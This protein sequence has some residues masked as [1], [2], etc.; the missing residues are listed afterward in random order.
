MRNFTFNVSSFVRSSFFLLL[1]LLVSLSS[2]AQVCGTPGGDGPIAITGSVNTYFPIS[3]DINLNAGAQAILLAASPGSDGKGNNFGTIPISAGD[4]ILII[5][6]QDATIDYSDNPLYG[7]GTTNSGKDLLGGTGFLNINNT[8]IFEYVIATNNVPLAGGNLTF[9]GT[10]SN[11]GVRNSFFN[12]KATTT[13]GQR[14]FQIVRVPQYSNLTLNSIITTPPFNGVAG[15]V[16][17]FNVSGTFNFNGNIIDGSARGFRGGYSPVAT[18]GVNNDLTYVGASDNTA[19]SGKGEGIAG[20]PRYMWDGFSQVDNGAAN[21]GLPGGSSGRGAPAN[22]GGGGN[23]HNSGGGGGGN[24][25]FGGLGGKGWQGGGGATSPRTG[26]GR[27]GFTS[28]KTPEPELTRLIMGGGG[29][30]GDANNAIN[31]V[32]GGV[33]GAIILINAGNIQGTGTIKANGG[34]GA[35]GSYAGAPDGAG[36]GG[37]G[38]SVFLNISNTNTI[39]TNVTI[40]ANG[41]KG[42][43]TLNDLGNSHGPGGG[44]GGGIIRY[45]V[46][47]TGV[48]INPSVTAGASGKTDNGSANGVDHGAQPGEAGSVKSF[49]SSDVPPNLQVNAS[50]FPI[51]ETTVKALT[52]SEVCG[53]IGEKVTYEI[54]IKNTGAG[55]AAGVL[56]DFSFPANIEFDAATASYSTEASGPSGALSSTGSANNPLIGNFNIAQNGVVTITLVGRISGTIAAGKHSS[57]AQAQYL[58]PT[59]RL[60]ATRKIT[61]A[62]N[63]YGTVNKKYEGANQADVPGTNFNG[64]GST[65]IVDDIT[66]LALPAA[67]TVNTTQGN[68]TTPTGTITVTAPANGPSV[69]YTLTG[70]NPVTA[71]TSNATGVFPGLVSGTYQVTT[72][73][74]Q[75]CTSLPTT[76]IQIIA[77]PGAPTTTGVSMCVGDSGSLKATS[78]SSNFVNSGTTISGAWN[79]DTDPTALRPTT[80]MINSGT[81]GFDI[82][83]IRNYVAIPFQ[84]SVSGNYILEMNA[85]NNADPMGYIVSGAFV[86]GSCSTGNW[87]KGDDDSAGNRLPRLGVG[88]GQG[89]MTLYAGTTYTLISTTYAS[90]TGNISG[91]FSWLVTSRPNGGEIM[92]Q[93]PGTINWY[94]EASGGTSIA[95]GNSFDPVGVANSGVANRTTPISTI[96]YAECSNNPGCRTATNFVIN[97]K[98]TVTAVST[99]SRCDSGEVTLGATASSGTINWYTAATGGAIVATGTSYKT[100]SLSTTTDYYVEAVANGCTSTARTK[101]TATVNTTPTI[102]STTP[103]SGC[104]GE[105][106]TLSAS[107]SAGTINWYSNVT[108]GISLG[109]GTSFTTPNLSVT[110]TYY[111]DA[112]NNNCTTGS[113]VAVAATVN[114]LPTAYAVTGGGTYCTGGT[115]FAV[116]L[117][118][119]DSGVSYQ[120]QLGGSNSGTAVTGTGNAISFGTK[121]TAGTYTVIATNTGTSCTATMTGSAVITISTIPLAPGVGTITHPTCTVAT[122]SVVLS[123]LPSGNWTINPGNITGSTTSTTISGLT[124]GTTY[125]FTVTNATGCTSPASGNVV[126]NPQPATPLAP[127][128]GTI[129]HPT[130]TVATGSAVLS[131]LPSGNWTIN[132][133]NITGSTTSTTI[134][135]LTAGTTYNFTVRNAAGC[136]SP[137]SGNVVINAQP[138]LPTAPLATVATAVICGGFTANWNA[139]PGVTGYLLDVATTN[140]FNGGTFVLNSKDVGN[141]TSFVVNGL[142]SGPYY[143]R[144]WSVNSCGIG[145]TAS[146]MIR[147]DVNSNPI[148]L[149]L[150]GSTICFSPG[151]NGTITS[152]S[153]VSG[154]NYQLYNSSN[155]VVQGSKPGTGSALTWSN[156]TAGTGYYVVSSATTGI[157]ALTC[158]TNS[159]TVDVTTTA[160]PAGLSLTGST[161]CVSPGGN[162]TITSSSSVSGVNY[163]LY[164]SS[165]AVVQGSKPGTGSALTWSNLTAGTGYYVVSSATTGTPGLTCTTNSNTV[166]VETNPLPTASI[167]G[168][169]GAC[170]TTTLNAVTNATSP[171]YVWYKN[172]IEISG[173][174]SS[175]LVVNSDGDYK[176]KVKN[177]LTGCE[178]TSAVSTVKVSDTEKPAKPVLADVTGECSATAT[179]PTTTDTCSGTITGTTTDAVSYNTQGTHIITWSFNDGNGNVETATQKVIVKD[180]QK[181]AK[182]VLADVT[183]ECSATATAPTTTDTCSGTITGTTTDAVSY[184]TQ[185]THIITWSFN[186]GNGNVETATQKVIVKDTQKPA[187]PV[188]ADVTGECSAT[189]TAPT[190][191]DT[192]SGTI[193]GTTTDAVSYNT[194]GTHII[195]WSFNDGNG[196]VETATQKVIVKDTQKP[197]KPVL[198]DVTGECSATATAPTTTDTCSGTITGTT[199]DAV[200][201]NTQGT[202]IITWSFNDGN[203]NVE[204]ATQKVI[205]KDTQKPAK[206]VLADVTGECSATATA[207]TTTDT[208]SGTITGT[209]TDAVS[210]NTQGTHIITWSFNDG[211]GNVETATQ[212]VI[213]KDTQ[214]PA[215]PVLADV[216]GE[217]SATATAPTTT[218]TCSGTITG[219]T[220]DAVSYNTQ[221]THIITWSFNDGNGNVETATQKVIVKDTQKPA[222]PVL[223]DVTGECSATAT[224]P[225]TTDTCSGTIT[226]TTTD[227][228]SYNT[229]GTHIITWSFNDGNGN[230]ETAT[231]KV[232]VK[233]TQKP[234]K[235]VLA[236]VTGECSA[237][238]TAPTTTDTCSG[239]ITGT[240]TDAVSYN[241]QGTHIITWSFN[242]GNG[243]V[244]TATQKVIVKDTQKPAK[245]VLADVTGECSAT[246]T[247][248]T[249]TDTC[250]GTI[251]GTTTDAVSYNTQ[252]THIITW[253][254]NDGNGN[255]ETATQKVIVKDTQKPAKP[256]LA[257]VTGECSATATAPTTTDTC[258]GTITGTT[259]DAVSYNTQGTH[260]IT[261]SFNDGNGNVET[262]T[263]KVIVKDTQK[264]AKPVLADVTGECSATATAPTT[265]DTCSGT[266]TGTTT[267]AVSYNTQGTHII[268]WSFNDG[269]GNVETATQ[270]VIVKDTQKPAKP[271]LAD[272]TGECSATATAPTTT[273][274]CSGTIT[275]TTT[276]AVSYNTQG[277]HIITWSFNDGNG[278]VETATQKVIVKDTQKPAKPVLADVTGE[279]SAT[280]TAPTTTDTCSGTITGTTTDA[281]SYNTQ[282]THI[283]T[284]SFNDGNGN[285]E[286]ATQK[287]IV[288]DTQKPAKPVL[289]DVTGECSATA[290][291]PTTTDT[292]SGTITGTTT[293]AVSYNTQGTHI[294]TWS[295][296]DGNGNVETATQK[297]IVKDTQ[298]PAKPVLADVTGEC[299]ATATAPTTTDTCSGTITG[300][301]TDAVSY[302]TQGTHI[303]TW[304]FN[305]GNGNVETATQKVIV[306]DTQKP[307]KPVLADVTGECSATATAPTTTDTCSGT[308]TGTTTDAVSYNTQGTH[309]ITWSFNDGN[310]NVETATQKVIVKDTQKPAKPVL[311]DVTGECSATATAPTTTDTCSGTITGT[312]TDAVSYNTQGTH[313]ITWSFNDGNGNVETA[314]QKVIV[315]DTQKPAKPVLADVTGECSATATAPTT[316][317][318]CSGTITGTTTDAVSYNTQGTHIITWSFNDGNG[319]VET[320]TQKVIV[321]DTQKPAKPVL[322]DVTGE[323]SATATAPTTTDTCSGTITGTTTDAVSYNTQGTHIITWSFNDGNGNVETAT[324]KVIVKDTQKPAK[325]VLA[326]VTGECSATAT[327]PTTTD[328][329]SGTITGTTTDAVSY[330]TQGTH[331]ITWSFN[332]GNGNVETA[333]QKVIVKDTQKPA[334][335][336]LADVTGECSATATAPTTTDTCSGTITGTTTD[337]VSYNTQGTHIITWSFNDGNGNVETATQKV[338]VKD[339]QKPAKP[340]LADVTGECSATATAPTTTDT[341]SGTITGTTTDAV[342]Y[343]TQG[344][345][346]ITWSFNDG[347][348]NVETA[349]QKVIVKDTQKPAKPVLADVTGECSATATAPTTTDTCSGTITGTTTDAVSYNTQGTHIITWSFNDGNGNVETATQKVIVK[350]TQKPAKPVLADVTGECSATATAPTTTDTCSGTITGTTT[351]AVSYNTQGTHIITWSFNDG[352]GNVETATQKVI[353]KDTQKPAKPVL[354]DVTGECSA[355]AT[356]PTT[357]DTCSGTITGTTTDAVSYN[358]QGTHIITW[359]FNDGN[360]NVE[361]ATQKVIVKDTQKPAK[362]VLADVTGECSATATAPTT[363]DTCSGTITG[364]TTDAVSYNTQGTHIITWSFNDGNGNVETATQKVIVKDT[365]KPAKPVL[366]DVTGECSATATAPTTTDTCSGTITGT[367]TD[368]VS[369]N[370]QGTHIITWSFNDGNGN[371]ETATQKVIVKD[372]QKPAKPVLADVTGECSATATA[373]TTTDTCSGTITGT[374]TDAVSYN[375]QG[376]HII[377]WSFNDGNGN[378]ETATQKVIVKDTQKPAKPVLADV[379]GECSATATAPTTTDTCSGTITG[380]TTDAVSYNTQGTHIITWSFND[381]NGNV[382][383]ATQKVIVKDTQKPAKPVLADVTG[384]CSATATAPT[385]TD[386]CSG[387]ITGTTTDAVSYNTQGTH[388]ITWSFN[389]GNGN[390]ETATQKVIVKDTQK[391]AKPVLADVTGECSATA[392]APTTTDTCSGTITGTTTDAVSYNTQGTHIITWSFNDGNGNVETAT[393]KVIVKDTQKPAKPVLAD[394]T[395]ECSATATAPTTTDTCS[396]TIT[397]TT[398]DAVSYNTQGTHIITWSFNDGNGNVETATQKVIVKD[399]Q[400]PAKPVLADV[401]GECSATATAPTTTDTC[402]GTITGTT[403]DA[404]SYNTQGTH[405][406]TWS[407]NDGNGNVE[408]AT[409][410]VIVKDTQKPAKPVLADVTGECSATATA[411]TTTDT[412]SGTITGTTTDAVSYNT[413]GTHIITWSF[414]DGNGNVET[415]TQKV[416]VKDT[417]KPA[418]PVLADVTGECSATAT[419]PTTTDTCSGTITGTTTDAVSYNTQ[420]T[421][422]ITWSF[423]DG[424]GN[425]E[426]ATQK[427]IVKDTQKPA[428]PVLADV[429]GEC[430]ATATAPTTTDTC[431]G[432]ITGTT[433]DAVS[434]NTQGT[435]II[436]WS[437][438]DGNGNVE[439]A[440]QKVIVKDTQK[441]AKPV[442]ADVTG[443]CSATATAPTTTDTCSGTITGTTTDAVSYNTQGTHIIT[444]SFNDGNGNVETATQKVIVKDTQKP[445][446]PVLADVTGECSA[447]ATAPTTTDTCS[448]TITGTTTDAV[449]YNTQGTHII[450]WSFNDGNGNVETATQKVIVKDT[451]KPAKPVLADVTGECSA[452]ATAPTTTDTCSG[453]ITGTTTDAVSYNTQGTHIITWSFNDGNGNVETATQKVIVKDTQK[454]AKPVLADVTGECSATAT[455]PTTTDTC[456]GTITGT[457]T[458]AVSY[459]TQGTHIITWSFNDGNGNVETATQK[460]IVKDT[461]KPAKPVLADVTGECSATATAPTTTDTCSGTITGTTTDAVSYNTQGT[462]IITWSFNDGNGNVETATQK[463]IV[464]DTQKPAKPVLADVTGECSATATAPTTTD[465]CSGTITGT[466][467]DAVSYNTQGTHIITWSFNDGNGNVET[468]TQKVIVKDTQKPAKPVLA[469]VTGECSATA[470]APTTTD[471]CS[472]TITGTTTDAVSYNTQGT[473]IIT[474]SFNDGNGNVETA[475]Q[476]VIV[477]DTQKPAKPVLADV[478]GECSATA[479]APTTTDTCSGTITG[480]TT[481]AVSYN[482]QG[483]HII[484]WSF[485]DGNGNVETATQKVI[486]KDTQKPAKPVLAD[487]TGECSATATAP[488]TTDTCS[489]TITG[490]T[491]D[492]VS[493]NTQGTHIITWSFNDGNGNVETAT[494]KVIIK[495]TQKPVISCPMAISQNADAGK[496]TALVTITEPTATDNC[497]TVFIFT[498]VRSD[499]LALSVAYPLGATTITW[500][501]EDASGNVSASCTQ[502][503][504]VIGP[505]VPN[506]DRVSS[507]N[508]YEGGV[509]V[510]DILAN[511]ML[512]CSSVI[513]NEVILTLDSTLPSVLTF[514]T[515]TGTVVVKPNTP[516]GIYSFNYK[517]CQVLN[518]TNCNTATVEVKVIAPAIDAVTETTA[519]IN[520]FTGGTTLTSND[521]LNGA[522]VVIGTNPG[523]VKLTPVDVPTG[524]TL[525]ADG[526]V[527]VAANTPAKNY[528]VIYKICEVNNPTNCDEV[529]SI[530]VVGQPIIDA[531]TETTASING[532]TGGN[533]PALTL[534]DKLNGAA[535]VIGTNPGE[536]KL[537]PVDVPT[538]LTLN[539]GGTVTVAANTPAKNYDVIYKICEVNNPTNCDEVTSIV[540]VGQPI[541]DA[542]TETTASINGFT[543][544]NTP[545]LTL[546][547]KL[548]GAAVV[549]GTNPGEVKLTPVDVPTGLTLNADGTVTVAANTP[550]K[551]YNV[552]YKICEVNNPTN[553]DEVTSIVVVGQPIIDAVTETTASINGFTGGNTPALTLNDKLNGAAVVIGTNPGEVKLTPVDVPTGLT[554]NADGTVTVA[555]NT[556]AKNYDVIYKICE[557]NNPTNCDEV[558]SIVVVGQPIIDAVTETTA[559]IN[560]FTGGTT[561]AL[562]S[563]DKLNGAAVV[564]GTNPGEVKLTPVD[565]PTGLTLN[566]DGTVTVAA[567]TPAKNYNVIYKICEVNNPTNCDEVTSIVVVGQ[568]IIDAVTE[569]TASINGFTGGNTPALTLND[570]LNGAAVVIGTN[571]GEVKLTPVDVPTGLTLNADGTVTVAANTPAK[572]YNVIYKICEV[573]NPTNCDEVTSIVV[574]G[575]PIIDAVTETTASINGFTGGNT[576]AL[577]LNDKLNGAAVVIGTNPGEVKLTP[578]DVPTGLTLNADGTVTVAA[579]TPAKNYNVI[580]KICEVNNPT[581]CDEVTSIVVVG[582]PIIDAVTET[583]AS[584]NGFTGGNT[585][586]LTLNDELNGAAVVIGTN[587]GEVKLTPV[588]VPTGLTL[589][590]DGT[591]TVAANTPAKNYNVIYK[592]CEVNNPTNC[593]E[594]TSIVVVGQPIIDAVTETTASINGFT[595]GN[596]PALTLNDKLNGAAVV[597]GTNPGEVKLTPVDVPTG[598]TLNADG[599]VTVAANTPAKNYDVIYK[600]CEVNNPTNCDEVTSIVVVG[601]PII[602]AV[603]ETT[604]SINGFTGGNTP[605]L[606]LN[607]KLNGAAVVIGTNPGEVKLTPVDVPT[608]LTLNADG[609]VTVAAN[610]PAKNYN[611]IYKI[612]EVNNPT[613]CDEVTSIVVV[614][615]PIIDAVTE[616]TASING[617]T[618]GNTPALTLNDELNGAAV[619]IGTNPGEVKLTP[620]DVPT[621][622]TLNADGTV[623]VAANTPAKNY[624]VI[625]K[626]CEVNNPTNCDEVTSIVV[627][628]KPAIDAITE[629]TIEINGSTGGTTPSLI[630]NDI[631]NGVPVVIK[632]S[633]GGVILTSVNVTAGLTLNA[634]GTVKVNAGTPIGIYEIEYTICE[635]LNPTNCATIKSYIPVVGGV[636]KANDD[637]GG[638]IDTNKG[639]KP[640]VNIF[641]NDMLNGLAVNPSAVILTTVVS[642]PNLILKADGSIEVKDGT[643]VGDYELTYQICEVLN[644]TNC[645]QAKVKVSVENS[646]D[647]DPPVSKIVLGNDQGIAD[648]INGS[649]EFVNVLDNDFL[650]DKLISSLDIVITNISKSPYFEFNSDGTVNMKPNTPGGNYTIAYQV[651][652]K[653]DSSNCSTGILNVFVEVPEIALVKTA[654]FND[655]NGNGVANAGETITYRFVVTNTGN[656][657]LKGVMI[658]DPL[659]GVKVFGQAIDLNVNESN[660]TNFT[661]EYKI[662]QADINRGSVSNQ[663]TVKGSSAKGVVVEDASDDA[664]L[665]GDKPTVLGLT[666]CVIKVFNA[667]SPNG[668]AKNSRFYIQGL[669]CY[670]NNTVEIYNRWGVL[671]FDIDRYNN[672]DRVFTGFSQGRTTIKESNGLPVGTYF[673]IIKYND[674]DS[675]PHELSGYLYLNK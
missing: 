338:I 376:T 249:T 669:E 9:K 178:E 351:D 392:T 553:C 588:D 536:V 612:C 659:V 309:I 190:T 236:D 159:N 507:I 527:T 78:C 426:T 509:A 231:Q 551:N 547:D 603:T 129:T 310:G 168:T 198:A 58:D 576:P 130:C 262:A 41:G 82:S 192:C 642:N 94:K 110:T 13:R 602:D 32:K 592:I 421:H 53:S 582:Q 634:D 250:S 514:D 319:N 534:N 595:G 235:P 646:V 48:T 89:I 375:T 414:N 363:T 84:V 657:P 47:G 205:V 508:G 558:T 289:A 45:N 472:G 484:T 104:A 552:I 557:V 550:A 556:P 628:G 330:N 599:T 574:V 291:A 210:Y 337:A 610:T 188:L 299:S 328:T 101:V 532:F 240:T 73:N 43:N 356:A 100:P 306:K 418:K 185:G 384:E 177:T 383:T 102:I 221:G 55:N 468:A 492:A 379:T 410:K 5:Q 353:V 461:Q 465:T 615:Q 320:A 361:T 126:I 649:L 590:A 17:A 54:Q 232:I 318:T 430:S 98:P 267:D 618:G 423:N 663:A 256:V 62:V 555:A 135:G 672:E 531:V 620:V 487:V 633:N 284:W 214:K 167:T 44:G 152:S 675:T 107:A 259:T 502:T 387:T 93:T 419:A 280:A 274:T 480:T 315:K 172:N 625:Y 362:P 499:G 147:V 540:V 541:I 645:S 166:N 385:T 364:T 424:N 571:P 569:T 109:T 60:D 528:N 239:T 613:N 348:G 217:C 412:C 273:D 395:G 282:G 591:V 269:N 2:V 238:A 667:F 121:T 88:S 431:S 137:A 388:I 70:T 524:L 666:G 160:N 529:T 380:T 194:Q 312:T 445:A 120:L 600:I 322:A 244:E 347:N 85:S 549:I 432:T 609:T 80:S 428:K 325:P 374:T 234:A 227:A 81:C 163:Q 400:K 494:Q 247:A 438:N 72:T 71:P 607:D 59:R 204:T 186:D 451:Q 112:T 352:N 294:I 49:I 64:V 543:G 535:V 202:H 350:D 477:K 516:E 614:G 573:N 77:V 96:F 340:V 652:E 251:T 339:T 208:C 539:A 303:I 327:A 220:T 162:G 157:P 593:D 601:Q 20:T 443:E 260:I 243:N 580:Y 636:L 117:S 425:V 145:A 275:G 436:T 559:S 470:T 182:P 623:T 144:V 617:F 381:G 6:M 265:T 132:P 358:T 660:D 67:P 229:Q 478:T 651:C 579:N 95:S 333:T 230:V 498:G 180:T 619:V 409:Q 567:N 211:N 143:Y 281:V 193:T 21:E 564:I 23:D 476:K 165:N 15:G 18:T 317:D 272:V 397:G 207:P 568:P 153:S 483:T 170:L 103:R 520:G 673:Y 173:Q 26:G 97:A 453:T 447:T 324:Q 448:G 341:C 394:V 611:V 156:L 300:T 200:S 489:G 253:S 323:C 493:Y 127:G 464:K 518:S 241:T 305:D 637:N 408:T 466:T 33:G 449:S 455:A 462:H 293:D 406:I 587:P 290:T 288:K 19:I 287:V 336:V 24:G 296:N 422:I 169:L 490:T 417:Q 242:D 372:T 276:D 440:T 257:D 630:L 57:S 209:T 656:V 304:S 174:T 522:A 658:N 184:N 125:N 626:I 486:V 416:I 597:I 83:I 90:S 481:D 357:T 246:A 505:I 196:N 674:S 175:S 359:S 542:V 533:T 51:L 485:N 554:L 142:A 526:T 114:P 92:L 29:G 629:R 654:V 360:G 479:T 399:T 118:N 115:G 295:F 11:G 35:P 537:T 648:G 473:H 335:P 434:Y 141:V 261:W 268:T 139:V 546:N 14:T 7:S 407:F 640:N 581:N 570:E 391:P 176:V 277:T 596:T 3:G 638:T 437:F 266:I 641:K 354:A 632:N 212:K 105:T 662:T 606:T 496:C 254:F 444:W 370:T 371:V 594:V 283:I 441:P 75:G 349:T 56:L 171:S 365:Q 386:T 382:E 225:T 433:T 572:N 332:D 149:V 148:A 575:Q 344:T 215:K 233:D 511:D 313:I 643:P 627:V 187:K 69:S 237:T 562:T 512:N 474:W 255:V 326:D 16:I 393:Q 404:V 398:T 639:E 61:A 34:E 544:G 346:I 197:A 457:T 113:R 42:G 46:P 222:K 248:P 25:G 258:S 355:T 122:G 401:T 164:N 316:T 460:V 329:C 482:T 307:A 373:P 286:T 263:Q 308:I 475:T 151:G 74:S 650:N 106:V 563:N 463:V 439:T 218:D 459:N 624:N 195:T 191:T 566:A 297:V 506:D 467:T 583:T 561:P 342:S 28:F 429:T 179:A 278:N 8:G 517:I 22:A 644:P 63:G 664:S 140:T 670:P 228:V 40:E 454:P 124:A 79:R 415:A 515:N 585:P 548:N 521:K 497:S 396:G 665:T 545:A 39:A 367:T 456:S 411:P 668:D 12:A 345:H 76:G 136:T 427:V 68:C 123:G 616:T 501:V 91:T 565:V 86:P 389:D 199:T 525:N 226:G 181:P 161:I 584:I 653:A 578:V 405:I 334:K 589:N 302:N 369:Y 119:S 469:D 128:V 403:T 224:A 279:C 52:T 671:V 4:L 413:Q 513:R 213:V 368:A 647:P 216:T 538:G 66:I 495:D 622:L 605:A 99:G 586:A 292:C 598:L 1:F 285:V 87:I 133:G 519:S 37:A 271:V 390:V 621:G 245:P 264:P 38:G 31:G 504:K 146:N 298:K 311:A 134:S 560:G 65:I 366:A 50:C 655:E 442:L 252:G 219:T 343:N 661:A 510:L 138:V 500:I 131:G 488:T 530:V 608:G 452:T 223:A 458:D 631:L 155:A 523:E 111:V 108:G 331:I 420:G 503:V 201:Y 203:G 301:T 321:K 378:V 635:Y 435:H 30:A 377:T 116:G 604:A 446:K 150:T 491:T 314:T 402:S 27:P 10:G 183:G 189:A 158:T 154:V 450:T 36:G 270:K 206:P 577:T 471:T